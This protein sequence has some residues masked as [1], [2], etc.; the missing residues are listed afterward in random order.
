VADKKEVD[1]VS[2]TETTGHEWD[3]IK[4]LNTPLPRWWLWTFYATCIWA[5]G[6][7]IVMP[8]WPLI[9]SHT[10][11]VIGYSS[12]A[13]LADS[14]S[15]ARAA[16]SQYLERIEQASLTEITR[17]RE[18]L[19]FALAGGGSAFAVNCSQCHG[20][21][22]SGFAGYPNLN[23]DD[24]IWG[25]TLEAIAD[26]I[27]YGIRSEHPD[28]RFNMMPAFGTDGILERG[29]INDVA[30]YVLSLSNAATD[31]SAAA[32]GEEIFLEQCA[33]CHM[34][35]GGGSHDLGAPD[36][37]NAIWLY[38]GDKADIVTTIS[39]SRA[40]MMPA[41]TGRLDET[42]IKQLAVYVHSLGGGQ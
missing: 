5:L 2:G 31:A 22:A 7:W 12:R 13:N 36:L 21:G 4:E 29:Q 30:E 16:Q 40:G 23:D 15:A 32:R 18:L 24:W 9:S 11:G 10:T 26:T 33:A 27:R 8:A 39:Q 17:D 19:E 38:G 14:M 20:L 6:Y 1:Q 42:T 28:T 35:D 34:D 41:W 25:G 37:T 3:G